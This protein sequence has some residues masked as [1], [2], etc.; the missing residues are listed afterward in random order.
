MI[1]VAL[2][3]CCR[4]CH[5]MNPRL[6]LHLRHL[7][8][9]TSL[10]TDDSREAI[11]TWQPL[12]CSLRVVDW[13]ITSSYVHSQ[14]LRPQNNVR[15]WYHLP[16]AMV[17]LFAGRYTNCGLAQQRWCLL[18][19]AAMHLVAETRPQVV[20]TRELGKN[21]KLIKELVR[22]LPFSLLVIRDI[23]SCFL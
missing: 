14:L 19:S 22:F 9:L 1:A 23:S 20:V 7:C 8:I 11:L 21:A 12:R 10:R 6:F 16:F 4:G 2:S 3:P 13:C 17:F 5:I 18:R 15:R